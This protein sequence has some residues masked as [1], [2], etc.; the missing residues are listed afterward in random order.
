MRNYVKDHRIE[1]R[2]KETYWTIFVDNK[3]LHNPLWVPHDRLTMETCTWVKPYI[4]LLFPVPLALAE[5]YC[6]KDVWI[7]TYENK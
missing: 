1:Q 2:K 4:E 6:V 7:S 3:D 5:N